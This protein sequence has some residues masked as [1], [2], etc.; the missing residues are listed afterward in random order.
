MCTTNTFRKFLNKRNGK[1][2][3]SGYERQGND[4]YCAVFSLY[5]LYLIK[6]FK[7][8][9]KS[10]ALEFFIINIVRKENR[11]EKQEN[12]KENRKTVKDLRYNRSKNSTQGGHST[13]ADNH[14]LGSFPRRI[15]QTKRSLN[16]KKLQRK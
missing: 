9:S 16:Q 3:F 4:S 10:A 1:Y 6:R 7:P 2:V 14:K 8:G 12:R 13:K 15:P 11:N 5:V